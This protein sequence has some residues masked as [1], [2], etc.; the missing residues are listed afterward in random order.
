MTR[1]AKNFLGSDP[2]MFGDSNCPACLSQVKMLMDSFGKS[3]AIRYYDLARYP[4]PDF[5]KDRNGSVSMPTWVLPDG[6]MHRGV[7]GKNTRRLLA[8]KNNTGFGKCVAGDGT[9]PQ[10]NSLAECGKNFPGGEGF[11]I[12]NSYMNE[13]RDKWGED[14]LSAGIGGSRVLAPG[15]NATY[16]SN[17]NLNDIRMYPPGGQLETSF[18]LNRTCNTMNKNPGMGDYG[19][20]YNSKNPQIVG[21]GRSKLYGQ[22]GGAYKNEPLVNSGT[23]KDLYG[24]AI[25]NDLVRPN[26]VDAR[27]GYVGRYSYNYNT[28]FG[29]NKVGEGS[30]LQLKNGKVKVKR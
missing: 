29:R 11:S 12:P 24:G 25:Q 13:I 26:G 10:L 21:F 6:T 30:V 2:V 22:M 18:L 15:D 14:Y 17:N 19:M 20:V 1:L 8:K 28:S 4:A 23:V 3:G 5:I 16:Y 9:T 27:A 7:I